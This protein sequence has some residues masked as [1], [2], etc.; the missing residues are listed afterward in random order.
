M[1]KYVEGA[2]ISDYCPIQN[3]SQMSQTVSQR[4]GMSQTIFLALLSLFY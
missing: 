2:F 3:H 4:D 1:E